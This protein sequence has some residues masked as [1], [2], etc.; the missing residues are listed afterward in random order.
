M[1]ERRATLLT[2][3]KFESGLSLKKGTP[4]FVEEIQHSKKPSL[5]VG[6]FYPD[7]KQHSSNSFALDRQDFSFWV[8]GGT[9]EEYLVIA[10]E[11]PPDPAEAARIREIEIH[12][13][14]KRV[15]LRAKAYHESQAELEMLLRDS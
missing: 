9:D 10:E 14:R 3:M 4:I 13:A 8:R 12:Q 11:D 1:I 2:D 15:E 7:P 6:H 5:W